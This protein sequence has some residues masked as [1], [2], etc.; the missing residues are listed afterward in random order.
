MLGFATW[1]FGVLHCLALCL[2][3]GDYPADEVLEGLS[4]LTESCLQHGANVLLMTVMEVAQAA[5][6]VEQQRLKLNT[7]I[8]QYVQERKWAPAAEG[9]ASARSSST[10]RGQPPSG[11]HGNSY[12]PVSRRGAPAVQLFDLASKLTWSGMDEETRWQMWDDGVH[13]TID[14]YDLMG[15]LIMEALGPMVK[16]EVGAA[17]AAAAEN[18]SAA[19]QDAT[20]N[21]KKVV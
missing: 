9:A 12:D 2:C 20:A 10:A 3:S 5:P 6:K 21:G 4:V 19:V 14:G 15:E 1:T 11:Q 13:L 17:A 7:L 16:Q 8:K 18:G